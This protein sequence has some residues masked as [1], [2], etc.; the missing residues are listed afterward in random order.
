MQPHGRL[1]LLFLTPAL[2]ACERPTGAAVIGYAFPRDGQR[3]AIVA[4]ASLP[5]DSGLGT[6]RIVGDWD[7]GGTESAVEIARARRLV[8]LPR[9]MGVVGHVGSRSTLITAPIYSAAGIPLIVP[10]A[11]SGRLWEIGEWVFPLAPSDSMEAA[12]LG[13]TAVD[14]LKSTRIAVYFVNT[15]YGSGIRAELRRWLAGRGM[16]PVDEVPYVVGADLET[17]VEAS[18]QRSHPDLTVLVGRRIEVARLAALIYERD[19]SIRLLAADGAYD[20]PA[21]LIAAAGPAADSLYLTTFWVADTTVPIQREF[22]RRYRND[23]GRDPTAFEAMRYDAVMVL[24]QAILEVGPD[25]PAIRDWLV[26]LGGSRPPYAGVTGAI[27]FGRGARR[28]LLLVR[29]RDGLPVSVP[30]AGVW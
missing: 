28:N 29:L 21:E 16:A 7:S 10:T 12:F 22:V 25:R 23:T 11:T 19:P 3:A 30:E 14:G 8:A 9:V 20:Q 13:E 18:L 1:A 26:S 4:A 15:A 24:A 5:A 2:A 17:L 27:S 6:I